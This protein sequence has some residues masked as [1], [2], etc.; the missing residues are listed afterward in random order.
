MTIRMALLAALLGSLP[1]LAQP[2][3]ALDETLALVGLRRGDLGWTP[4]AWWPRWPTAEYKLRAFAALF[5][6]PLDSITYARSMAE[7]A[8]TKLDPA[9]LNKSATNTGNRTLGG[10]LFQAVQRLGIDPKFGGFRGY[11]ANTI[12]PEVPLEEAILK[13]YE[14]ERRDT[15]GFTFGMELPYPRVADRLREA[16]K[17]VPAEVSPILGQLVL[18]PDRSPSLGRAGLPQSRSPRPPS[19]RHTIQHRRRNDR[20]RRLLPRVRRCGAHVG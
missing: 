16:V 2:P 7:A 4:K 1:S 5:A 15:R 12:A 13:I 17:T 11:S 3:D 6:E 10:S 9:E 14:L 18:K 8:W 19:R 20:R